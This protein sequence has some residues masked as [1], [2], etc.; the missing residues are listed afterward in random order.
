MKKVIFLIIFG[1]SLFTGGFLF[2]DRATFRQMLLQE[3]RTGEILLDTNFVYNEAPLGQSMSAIAFGAPN[4][5]VV[6]A[7][8]RN[9]DIYGARVTPACEII[10]S[11]GIEIAH[12]ANSQN[13]PSVTFDGT[14]YFVVW[15]DK[16]NGLYNNDI[17]G[18]RVSPSGV[19]LDPDGI[20]VSSASSYQLYPSVIFGNGY[21][22]VVWQDGRFSGSSY[23]ETDIYG[24]RVDLS[25]NVLD[26]NGIR[27]AHASSFQSYVRPSV[28]FDGI[29]Y[30]A[31]WQSN[32]PYRLY[33]ARVDTHGVVLDVPGFA[34]CSGTGGLPMDPKITFGGSYYLIV[35]DE[36]RIGPYTDIWGARI[37]TSGTVLDPNGFNIT[38]THTDTLNLLPTAN[39]DG[40]NY[41]VFWVHKISGLSNYDIYGAR[42]NQTGGIIDPNGI[43]IAT[44]PYNQT[45]PSVSFGSSDYFV[46]WQDNS[47]YYSDIYGTSVDTSGSVVNPDGALI[48]LAAYGQNSSSI[49]FDGTNYLV[50][51]QDYQNQSVDIYGVRVN[52]SGTVLESQGT[53]ICNTDGDQVSPEIGFDGTNYL[54]VWQD[55]HTGSPSYAPWDI[56]AARVDQTG[57]V[58][59]PGGFVIS[60][61]NFNQWC[62]SVGFDGTNYFVVYTDGGG[63]GG[64]GGEIYAIRVDQ[65]GVVLDPPPGI[66]ICYLPGS[67]QLNTAVV[68][69]GT[70]YL[71]CWQDD[72]YGWTFEYE[73]YGARVS[74]NGTV[75]DPDGIRI[76]PFVNYFNHIS[77][78]VASDS[79]DYFVVWAYRE[80][81]NE[82]YHYE[83]YGSRIDSS[84]VVI[85]T[86]GIPICTA[87]NHQK[88]PSVIFDGINYIVTWQD[89]RTGDYDI[90]GVVV[91]PSGTVIDSFIVS[92]QYGHQTDPELTIGNGNK[93]LI[94]YTGFTPELNGRP[95][96]TIR[97]WGKLYPFVAIEETQ[98]LNLKSHTP[99][100]EVYS[101]PFK[102]KTNIRYSFGQSIS[103]RGKD[104]DLRIYDVTGHLVKSFNNLIVQPVSQVVWDGTDNRN[105]TLPTGIY[106]VSLEV[107]GV[108]RAQM[109]IIRIE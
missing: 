87:D 103:G 64:Y 71:V 4:Y 79:K 107:K 33:G 44:S 78:A 41:F 37:D 49:S 95:A 94:T 80:W 46:A 66:A 77:P 26:P 47:N 6:W 30:L 36:N 9:G 32:N 7:D 28:A 12:A 59:D 81:N 68:F 10:D 50:V 85:D 89:N 84:G 11:V 20:A 3:K 27:L 51:W 60:G 52:Q 39:Y 2:G 75:L 35:W 23:W 98:V 86:S 58:L 82:E 63:T 100:L 40:N 61:E 109:K 70:N 53:P 18:A 99:Y 104:F 73:I 101:N 91:N 1:T 88:N 55:N 76:S 34:V 69:N 22:F 97:I 45:L 65:N 83:I 25:G 15:S 48:S 106:F 96:N 93:L 24:A 8:S 19:V 92:D 72:R 16:R 31:G 108:K 56:Y 21:Y 74:P 105:N 17:Y 5:L 102:D 29:N 14:N 67:N 54:V 57:T 13:S 43:P 38:Y 90:Y 62:P 42:V